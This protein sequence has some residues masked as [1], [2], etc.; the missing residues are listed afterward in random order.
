MYKRQGHSKEVA[1]CLL[2]QL[3]VGVT[4][5]HG[6]GAYEKKEKKI[7]LCATRKSQA[8]KLEQIVKTVDSRA[9]LIKTS[10]NEIYGEGYKNYDE[11]V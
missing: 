10:A 1:E 9:F 3:H 6:E 2:K 7:L 4:F 8:P 5:L 11:L